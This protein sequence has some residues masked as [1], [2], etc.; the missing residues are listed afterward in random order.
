MSEIILASSSKADVYYG[1]MAVGRLP[2][3]KHTEGK[4]M[5]YKQATSACVDMLMDGSIA[6]YQAAPYTNLCRTETES[7]TKRLATVKMRGL[8]R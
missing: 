8:G 1:I 3:E 2:L 5:T 4:K 6:G 7:Q